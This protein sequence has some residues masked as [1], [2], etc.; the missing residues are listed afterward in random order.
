VINY[1]GAAVTGCPVGAVVC[2]ECSARKI[3]GPEP[4]TVKTCQEM[5]V[6]PAAYSG[7]TKAVAVYDISGRLLQKS[8]FNKQVI[9]LKKDLG[10]SVGSVYIVKVKVAL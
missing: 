1:T 8:I 2:P 9:S 5:V 6:F 3:V 7:L 4:F 10:L